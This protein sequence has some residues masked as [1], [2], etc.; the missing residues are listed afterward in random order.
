MSSC[1]FRAPAAMCARARVRKCSGML[2][3]DIAGDAFEA[4]TNLHVRSTRVC[5]QMHAG[6]RT[7][8]LT[9]TTVH[10]HAYA[11]VH[12]RGSLCRYVAS[13]RSC[14]GWEFGPWRVPIPSYCARILTLPESGGRP[15]SR[16]VGETQRERKGSERGVTCPLVP[17]RGYPSGIF[18]V[19]P[20]KCVEWSE[21]YFIRWEMDTPLL[22]QRKWRWLSF[23]LKVN[24]NVHP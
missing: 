4:Y 5:A 14:R 11:R 19:I 21:K 6:L 3:Q 12:T 7:R 17:F 18:R 20:S 13:A 2:V 23:C 10:A 22:L 16:R 1:S 8:T 15:G 24:D 9:R